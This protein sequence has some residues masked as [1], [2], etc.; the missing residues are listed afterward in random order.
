MEK[1]TGTVGTGL[2][3]GRTGMHSEFG[4][5]RASHRHAQDMDGGIYPG[6]LLLLPALRDC[7]H[8]QRFESQLELCSGTLPGGTARQ[9]G[10][11]EVD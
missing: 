4:S 7:G 3:T 6:D 9:C 8:Y 2:P 11:R 5:A 10:S 1:R